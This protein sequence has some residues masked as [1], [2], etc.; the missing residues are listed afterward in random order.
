MTPAHRDTGGAEQQKYFQ[1][2]SERKH[3]EAESCVWGVDDIK[4]EKRK[5]HAQSKKKKKRKEKEN[6]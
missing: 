5:I 4:R 3:Q 6:R 1:C 2:Q